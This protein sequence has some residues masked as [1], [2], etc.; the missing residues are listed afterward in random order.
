MVLRILAFG[1]LL[2]GLVA[3]QCAFCKDAGTV[4]CKGKDHVMKRVCGTTI[5]H[6]C[7]V[8]LRASCCRGTELVVCSKCSKGQDGRDALAALEEQNRGW[9]QRMSEVDRVL[10]QRLIHVETKNFLV[11]YSLPGF[12][13]DTIIYDRVKGAHLFAERL[14]RLASRFEEVTGALPASRQNMTILATELEQRKYTSQRMG[15]EQFTSFRRYGLVGEVCQ[16]HNPM[17]FPGGEEFLAHCIHNGTHLLTQASIQFHMEFTDW[18]DVGLAHWFETDAFGD[19]R[20]FCFTEVQQKSQW[21]SGEWG[22]MIAG[23]VRSLKEPVFAEI[24]PMIDDRLTYELHAYCWSYV[25]FLIKG[26]GKNKFKDFFRAMKET[27]DTKVALDRVYGWSTTTFHEK[28][29]N[30]VLDRYR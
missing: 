13:M 9:T 2:T 12:T 20:T 25:D 10:G 1:L 15:V 23:R 18:F 22:K 30:Y 16:W 27:N 6:R 21:G 5:P 17:S 26:E 11:H 4:K 24:V 29:R 19:S 7:D 14:E 8:L 3:A 28:W